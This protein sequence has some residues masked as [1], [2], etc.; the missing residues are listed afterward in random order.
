MTRDQE[1]MQR[2]GEGEMCAF[3]EL[4]RRHHRRAVNIAYRFL[5]DREKAED[6]A[7]EAFLKIL[8]A[9]ARYEPSA[10]FTTY[11]YNVVWHIC[12]D[13]YRRKRPARMPDEVALASDAPLPEHAVETD[14]KVNRVRAAVDRL[15]QR[16]RMAL[17][18]KHYEE[19]S[20]D[21]I[22][23]ILECTSRA[24]DSLLVRARRALAELLEDVL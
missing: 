2:T 18:L 9:A 20:Y 21:E 7:Q 5:S 22:A 14:E 23:E 12:V 10:R 15:P 11:L 4:V 13:S 8:D 19:K 3:E 1:L 6:A 17:I 24:V 16:Q